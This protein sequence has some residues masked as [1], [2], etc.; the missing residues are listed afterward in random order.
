M[1]F[2]H[3]GQKEGGYAIDMPFG[4]LYMTTFKKLPITRPNSI[5]KIAIAALLKIVS[6][7]SY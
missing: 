1:G 4:T 3:D 6:S 5:T 2:L 7:R